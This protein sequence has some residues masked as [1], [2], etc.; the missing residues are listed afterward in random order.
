[1]TE[2]APGRLR[3]HLLRRNDRNGSSDPWESSNG[4]GSAPSVVPSNL[5]PAFDERVG[6]ALRHQPP[7]G[8]DAE[9]DLVRDH[10]DIAHYL[11]Q[12]PGVMDDPAYRPGAALPAPGPRGAVH[13]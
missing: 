4:N 11:L 2:A 8:E 9:Y 3:R 6:Q 5:G 1:M 13:P 7:A 12:A 10:F